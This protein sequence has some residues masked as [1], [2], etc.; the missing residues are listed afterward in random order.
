M[1]STADVMLT[2]PIAKYGALFGTS[3]SGP[4]DVDGD[5]YPDLLVGAPGTD[6]SGTV[7]KSGATF[8]L[9]G[10]EVSL[11]V[12][13]A[14]IAGK[15]A[16]EGLGTATSG[17]GDYDGDGYDDLLCTDALSNAYLLFGHP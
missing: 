6:A 12:G 7:T 3:L 1:L 10:A 11:T 4:G 9:S 14:R 15:T 5:G 13:S 2:G 8:L 16:S 17:A